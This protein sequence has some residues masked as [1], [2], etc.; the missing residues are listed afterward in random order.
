MLEI[1]DYVEKKYKDVDAPA[2][3]ANATSH[4]CDCAK[5]EDRINERITLI[6]CATSIVTEESL[7]SDIRNAAEAYLVKAFTPTLPEFPK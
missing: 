5:S 6:E 1:S 3:P 4:C 7:G 2:V